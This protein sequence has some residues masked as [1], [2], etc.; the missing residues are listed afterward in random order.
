VAKS[1]AEPPINDKLLAWSKKEEEVVVGVRPPEGGVQ[2]RALLGAPSRLALPAHKPEQHALVPAQSM[3]MGDLLG[4]EKTFD[5]RMRTVVATAPLAAGLFI[6]NSPRSQGADQMRLLATRLRDARE[7]PYHV[8]VI[9]SWEPRVGR[10][11][12]AANLGMALAEARRRTLLVDTCEG[13]ASLTRL[14]GLRPQEGSSLYEQLSARLAGTAESWTV[15]QV[16][17]ALSVIPATAAARPVGPMISSVAFTEL[18]GQIRTVYDVILF[19]CQ[20]LSRASDAVVLHQQADAAVLVLGRRRSTLRGAES[21]V[22]QL[23][24]ERLAGAVFNEV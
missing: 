14:F 20:P 18:V 12:V 9:C 16:A 4:V 5:L 19:D 23:G 1:V 22:Q 21:A 3:I 10:S 13:D 8:I 11:T 24:H 15:H 2:S 6:S 17:E 7:E